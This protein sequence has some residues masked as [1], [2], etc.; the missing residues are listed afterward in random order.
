MPQH[1]FKRGDLVSIKSSTGKDFVVL[2]TLSQSHVG[3]DPSVPVGTLCLVQR[4]LE[5][6]F[7]TS[8]E[9]YVVLVEADGRPRELWLYEDEMTLESRHRSA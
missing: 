4:A 1:R 6:K 5:D 2:G 7:I 3:E 9:A 8:S